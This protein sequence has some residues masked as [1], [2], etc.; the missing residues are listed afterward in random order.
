MEG[1][2]STSS[3]VLKNTRKS[4]YVR[5][6]ARTRNGNRGVSGLPGSDWHQSSALGKNTVWL[7]INLDPPGWIDPVFTRPVQLDFVA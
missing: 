5:Y 3:W 6:T 4:A 7:V 1:K 2:P